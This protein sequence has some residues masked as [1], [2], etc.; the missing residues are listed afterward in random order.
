MTNVLRAF[1]AGGRSAF[2]NCALE[3]YV[4]YL[5]ICKSAFYNSN[6]NI[7]SLRRLCVYIRVY[8]RVCTRTCK[9]EVSHVSFRDINKTMQSC[10]NC[11]R[12][13]YL[14]RE[15]PITCTFGLNL[16]K[17][18]FFDNS[19]KWSSP[20][21]SRRRKLLLTRYLVILTHCCFESQAYTP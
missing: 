3:Q 6:Y 13:I 7:I 4:E 2:T 10:Y 16:K 12:Y 19:F 5:R 11:A 15:R 1:P 18:T 17:D 8:I 9:E 20:E 21:I 14:R